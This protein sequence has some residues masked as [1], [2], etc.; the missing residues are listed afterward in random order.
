AVLTRKVETGGVAEAERV[1]PALHVE[2]AGCRLPSVEHR[3][4]PVEPG[5]AGDG[6]R[7]LEVEA[8]V[9]RRLDVVEDDVP[10]GQGAGA[11]QARPRG[12]QS[13][14]KRR[15]G[16]DRLEGRT[17]RIEALRR[18]VQQRAA[19]CAEQRAEIAAIDR[20]AALVE[21]GVA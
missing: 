14:R 18:A 6:E 1:R 4:Q 13:R 17:G 9:D 11:W 19:G 12:D 10:D 21:A 16:D 3:P 5:V 20:C 2:R 15:F 7:L 8:G